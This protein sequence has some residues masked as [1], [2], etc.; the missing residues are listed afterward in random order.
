M[1]SSAQNGLL[2]GRYELLDELGRGGMGVV[3]RAHDRRTDRAVAIKIIGHE[4][5]ADE[6]TLRRFRREMLATSKLEHPHS[7]RVYD[8]GACRDGRLYLAME[9]MTGVNLGDEILRRGALGDARVVAIGTQIAAALAAA[10]AA[11]VVHRDI[12]PANVMLIDVY[13]DKD[14]VKVFDFGIATFVGEGVQLSSSKLTDSGM[15]IGSPNYLSPEQCRGQRVNQASDLYSL[16]ALLYEAA[17]GHPP[18]LA[19][20]VP[21]LLHHH[22]KVAPVAPI[23]AA[24]GL[25]GPAL[26]A[27]I[28]KLLEKDPARR[29][30]SGA[31]VIA[32]LGVPGADAATPIRKRAR[33]GKPPADLERRQLATTTTTALRRPRLLLAVAVALLAGLVAL[34]ALL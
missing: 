2:A 27:T 17:T 21:D 13:G 3:H 14:F 20:N 26:N 19:E 10:H 30:R 7:V 25:V 6:K 9:L 12:K 8:Y 24:P 29:P 11:G 18:F 15:V 34:L 4:H 33:D 22:V 16:G 32:L 1:Q 28:L 23:E 5:A 31:E